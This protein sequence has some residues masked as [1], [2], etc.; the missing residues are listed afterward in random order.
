MRTVRFA[1]VV[2]VL[3]IVASSPHAQST[4]AST[5]PGQAGQAPVPPAPD[6]QSQGAL[7]RARIDAVTV[8][9]AVSDKQGKPVLD[10]KAEDF[11]VTEDGKPQK[12]DTF[13]FI[14]V[15]NGFDPDPAKYPE[16]HS[17][18]D[19]AREAARD[20]VRVVVIF[21]DDYHVRKGNDRYVR[22]QLGKWVANLSPR[23]LVAVMYPL[24]PIDAVSLTRNHDGTAE[25]LQQFT[26]R[27]YDY[28]PRNQYESVYAYMTPQDIETLRNQVTISALESLCT[29][30]GSLRQGRK[31]I[32]YVSEGMSGTLPAAINRQAFTP[33]PG[34]TQTSVGQ[35][36]MQDRG[37]FLNTVQLYD[38][39]K[40]VF[41]AATRSNTSIYTLDARGLAASEFDV[42]QPAVDA[43]T[44][45]SVLNESMDTLRVIADETDGRAMV[46]SNVF[47][48]GLD[49]ML[50]DSSS[51][52]L[53]GYTSTAAPRDGKFHDIRITLKRKDL[54]VRARKGYWAYTEED[55]VRATAP[56]KAALPPDIVAALGAIPTPSRSRP[57][58]S[59]IGMDRGADG[60]AVVT[61]VW[62]ALPGSDGSR[63]PGADRV[64]LM[65]GSAAGELLFHGLVP[66]DALAAAPSGR[67]TFTAKPG[68]VQLRIAAQ[69]SD[70][71]VLDS[72]QRDVTVPDFTAVGPLLSTPQVFRVRTVRD[73][74]QLA[75]SATALPTTARE[76]SRTE[77]L[78]IRF[79]AY[80]PANTAPAV[81]I[82]LLNP[83][84]DP[85]STLPTP[86]TLADG[87]YQIDLPLAGLAA[88]EY[89]LEIA[90]SAAD[91]KTRTLVGF[92]VSS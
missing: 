27:K 73:V 11:L 92:S 24:T 81:T 14:S 25:A 67:V 52:Y 57:I 8:D 22:E 12:I 50:A 84:G 45:R 36:V 34:P 63:T 37:T 58:R 71:A 53:L 33:P 10:L 16:I 85:M 49:Q 21:L 40:R 30:L 60:L 5:N 48:P 19:Q 47:K 13:K 80:G 55:I 56:S 44:D 78:V 87:T 66:K 88:G 54:V 2:L 70:G 6:P 20:D 76:F 86:A 61:F 9:A 31:S 3:A 68:L 7:F 62:E 51:Y 83:L 18:D 43:V 32:L 72:E 59:W 4:A 17:I 89:V 64:N 15:D 38:W 35:S 69:D 79:H 90:A 26:G 28:Q 75:A 23:D 46:N 82:R 77:R 65:A 29:Y 91:S 42:S 74:Q 39:M 1:T 41:E